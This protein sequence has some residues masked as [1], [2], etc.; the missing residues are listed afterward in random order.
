METLVHYL[1][2]GRCFFHVKEHVDKLLVG[3]FGFLSRD[4]IFILCKML[5]PVSCNPWLMPFGQLLNVLGLYFEISFAFINL[6]DSGTLGGK[7]MIMI[8]KRF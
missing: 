7:M 1:V 2:G 3:I 6:G 5:I 8:T 4:L